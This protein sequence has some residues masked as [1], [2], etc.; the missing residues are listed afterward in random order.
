MEKDILEYIDQKM[1]E[2]S[3]VCESMGYTTRKLD[4]DD[5]EIPT[6][7]IIIGENNFGGEVTTTCN[8]VPISLGDI[9]V[10]FV[11]FYICVS[12]VIS[13]Y[14]M[15][16]INEYIKAQNEMF[17][18]GNLLNF[19]NRVCVKYA[20]YLYPDEKIDKGVFTRSLDIFI[21]Q[22][23]ILAKKISELV[24]GTKTIEQQVHGGTL[25]D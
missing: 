8:L 10:L 19:Q 24:D 4:I 14:K 3:E 23:N 1:D 15:D 16:M 25:F 20:I 6:V 21:Y 7:E 9:P 17:M 5:S 13:D 2:V 18:I 12:D 22:A 11:Q